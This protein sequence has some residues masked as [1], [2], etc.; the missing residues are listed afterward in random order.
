MP[1]SQVAAITGGSSGIGLA[2][3]RLLLGRGWRVAIAGRD[4]DRLEAAA[5]TLQVGDRLLTIRADVGEAPDARRVVRACVERFDRLDALVNNAGFAPLMPIERCDDA[6][7][8]SVYGVNALGP[9]AS[10]AEAWPIFTRQRS[11]VVVNVSTYGTKD[12]FPGF[13]AYAAA[14]SAAESMI[15]SIRN[16]GASIGVR[17]YAVAPGAVETP[18]LRALFG[19]DAIPAS[20]TLRPEAV[21]TV[22]AACCTG[23]TEEPSGSVIYLASPGPHDTEDHAEKP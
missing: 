8:E 1:E 7:L 23:E 15:R 17:G 18:L 9:A 2:L 22:L 4:A 14:K 21:A 20:Q 13:F 19:E 10:I 3:A 12:P 11:G 6:F 16:E 5:N